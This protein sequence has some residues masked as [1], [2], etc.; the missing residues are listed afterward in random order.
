MT[1]KLGPHG[2]ISAL[3]ARKDFSTHSLVIE[4]G[5]RVFDAKSARTPTVVPLPSE[6]HSHP[7]VSAKVLVLNQSYEPISVCSA[8][9]ALLLMFLSKAE[10]IEQRPMASVRTVRQHYPFPSVIRLCAYLRIPFKKI[11]L[12]RKNIL[13]RDGHR[14]QYCGTTSPPLTV[15]HIIP[16]SRGGGDQWENLV[17]ACIHCNNKKG[18]RTPEEA[19]MRLATVP[20]R[21]H[22][23]QFLKHYVGKVDDTWRPYLFMD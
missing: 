18:N 17:C 22:H 21:P 16:R 4:E 12:S 13:R 23:V 6:R 8:K 10:L 1:T 11:E 3:S 9:K 5:G 7:A 20:R 15:D 19:N 2:V 14:C